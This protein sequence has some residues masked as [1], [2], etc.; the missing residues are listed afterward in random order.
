MSSKTEVNEW[1]FWIRNIKRDKWERDRRERE[2]VKGRANKDKQR[3]RE[4]GW[5]K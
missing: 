2:K 3:Q 4:K 5:N 1:H